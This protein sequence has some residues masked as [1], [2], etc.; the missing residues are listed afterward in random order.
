[1]LLKRKILFIQPTL[2]LFGGGN[3]VWVWMLEALC[4]EYD[5]TILSSESLPF[6]AVNRNLGLSLD[7]TKFRS[8]IMPGLLRKFIE[9]IQ[10]NPWDYQKTSVLMRWCKCIQKRYDLVLA[11]SNEFDFGTK[12][13]QY[14][15]YPYHEHNWAKEQLLMQ[16]NKNVLKSRLLALIGLRLRPWRLISG[17][18]FKRMSNNLTLANSDWTG[19]K[20]KMAYGINS[21]T[22]YPPVPSDFPEIPWQEREHGFVC[23][24]RLSAE[25]KF[26]YIIDTLSEVRKQNP[27]V[28]LHIIGCK[29]EHD[30]PFYERIVKKVNENKSWVSFHEELPRSELTQIVARQKYAIHA[31]ENEHFGIAVAEMVRAGCITFAPNN[32]GQ[33][34]IIG[35]E[36]RLLYDSDEDAVA[37]INHILGTPSEQVEVLNYLQ[38]RKSL[39]ST[40]K[41]MAEIREVV[42]EF[43]RNKI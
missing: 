9:L 30:L 43:M 22:I 10:K 40:E 2:P 15:H 27:E 21:Q 36:K 28:K 19:Q 42:T 24:G 31:M 8:L 34:E 7:Q 4:N 20:I 29:E 23:I 26:D 17:F 41:F 25:K 11:A 1:M 12:G 38:P 14:I 37:K 33:V 6:E 35:P 39:F 5:I 13:I 3:P 16:D 18:S 32:G